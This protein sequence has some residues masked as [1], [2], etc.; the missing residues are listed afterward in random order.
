MEQKTRVHQRAPQQNHT[1][2]SKWWLPL[3]LCAAI[4]II[5]LAVGFFAP[6]SPFRLWASEPVDPQ[7]AALQHLRADSERNVNLTFVN[8]FPRSVQ[9]YVPVTGS[10]PVERARSFL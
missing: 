5:L 6:F 4:F 10:D 7:F 2:K 3:L 9:G 1:S 8:G